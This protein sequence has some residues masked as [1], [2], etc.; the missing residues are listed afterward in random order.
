MERRGVQIAANNAEGERGH[1]SVAVALSVSLAVRHHVHRHF[2]DLMV[3]LEADC[4]RDPVLTLR[5]VRLPLR[6]LLH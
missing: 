4:R 2:V 3:L 6:C 5:E 1:V